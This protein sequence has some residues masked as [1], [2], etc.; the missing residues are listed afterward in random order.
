MRCSAIAIVGV[1]SLT[2]CWSSESQLRTRAAADFQCN[3]DQLTVREM[4]SDVYEVSGCG[5]KETYVYNDEARA[6]LKESESGGTVV[7]P[8]P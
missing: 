3:S 1:I 2:G 5:S 8:P 4:K 7:Q 6:W